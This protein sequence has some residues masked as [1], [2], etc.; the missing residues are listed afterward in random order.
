M[1]R[2]WWLISEDS[3]EEDLLSSMLFL[4]WEQEQEFTLHPIDPVDMLPF[5]NANVSVLQHKHP[6]LPHSGTLINLRFENHGLSIWHFHISETYCFMLP[7]KEDP[8]IYQSVKFYD[9]RV[10]SWIYWTLPNKTPSTWS[11]HNFYHAVIQI[12]PCVLICQTLVL[13]ISKEAAAICYCQSRPTP[14]A[15]VFLPA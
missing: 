10:N 6:N 14:T 2:I 3:S 13:T 15:H 5:G 1:I 7:N 12:P 9:E 4:F 11:L 8:R